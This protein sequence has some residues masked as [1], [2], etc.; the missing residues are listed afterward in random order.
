LCSIHYSCKAATY[1]PG[2]MSDYL[3]SILNAFHNLLFVFTEDGIISD[4]ITPNHE[5]ELI[6]PKEVFLGKHHR[7]VLP[8]HVS[9]QIER[10]FKKIDEGEKQYQF[11]YS[12]ELKG[13]TQWYVAVISK[14]EHGNESKYLGAVSN[15]TTRKNNE[16]LLQEIFNITPAAMMIF[17]TVRDSGDRIID[18]EITDVNKSTA[19]LTG[20]PEKQLIGQKLIPLIPDHE[21]EKTLNRLKSVVETGKSVD[22][23]YRHIDEFDETRWYLS[24]TVKF[25]DGVVSS[26]LDITEHKKT[27]AVLAKKNK[28]LKK[29]NRHKDKLFSVISHDLRNAI[30]G[31]IGLYDLILEDYDTLSKEELLEYLKLLKHKTRSTFDLLEDLLA[32]SKNQ[33]QKITLKPE[34]INLAEITISVFNSL[35]PNAGD[36][37]IGLKNKVPDD[38]FVYAD[39]NMVKTILRN[40]ISNGIKFSNPGGEIVV[41]ANNIENE[42]EISVTDEGIGIKKDALEK[43]FNKESNYTTTGTKGEKGSGLGMDLCIDFVEKQRG[44]IWA[45]SEPGKGTTFT[46]TLPEYSRERVTS[47]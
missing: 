15:I 14:I 40:L 41:R 10:A 4:Y 29:L 18:F 38:I 39:L 44:R 37:W 7:D 1:Y 27:E 45:E 2:N 36:K 33:F 35:S 5:D 19:R 32:W 43:I 47:E 28:E 16:L 22:Y 9:T 6:Q 17:Q 46:F 34:K 13:E 30:S 25:K 20:V 24:R 23:D 31:P 12:L 3:T 8:P 21:K 42:V 26:F 11:D